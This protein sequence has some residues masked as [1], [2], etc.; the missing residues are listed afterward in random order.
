VWLA[1]TFGTGLLG[2]VICEAIPFYG[3][4]VSIIG[5]LGFG[6]LG[7]CLPVVMWFCMHPD[8]RKGG[9]Q[10]KLLW[11]LHLAILAMGI[12]V[13]IGGTYANVVVIIGQFRDGAVSGAFD[14]ADNSNTVG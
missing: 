10:E 11:W 7:I 5:S 3:S 8:Y 12:F 2:W 1:S 4:L 6:P 14:C 9:L 13:T